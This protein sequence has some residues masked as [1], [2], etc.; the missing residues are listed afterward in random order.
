MNF[1]T[2]PF[3]QLTPKAQESS[4]LASPTSVFVQVNQSED[5]NSKQYELPVDTQQFDRATQLKLSSFFGWYAIPPLMPII[6]TQLDLSDTD[7]LNSDIA[8]TASTI[9]SRLAA[10]PLLDRY[11]PQVVQKTVLWLGALP[12]FCAAFV[13]S[14]T[15]LLALRFLIGIVGCVFVT[16]QYWT[17]ITF[18]RNV[19]G[20]AN[21]ITGGFGLSGIG[22]AFLLLPFIYQGIIATG[23]VSEDIGWR[24]TIAFPAFLMLIMSGVIH[25][26]VDSCPSGKFQ[27]FLR[28]QR[29]SE[30][31]VSV[32]RTHLCEAFRRVLSD[33]NV[34]IM[35]AHYAACFGTELQLN[36]MGA[37]YF[38]NE[39]KQTDCT[40]TSDCSVLT[41]TS[42]ATVASS[43]GLM[44]LFA[45]AVGGIVSDAM[46]CRLE[47]RGRQYT[48]LILLCILG[49]LVMALS[50]SYN[51]ALCVTL[52]VLVAIA[53]QATGGS[54]YSIV[55]YLNEEY[56]GTVNGLV[57]AGGN[58]GGAFFGVLFR[59]TGSYNTGLFYMSVFI[60]FC[61]LLT[62]FCQLSHV[63]N[64]SDVVE[65][66]SNMS[67]HE[68]NEVY[69]Q[70]ANPHDLTVTNM[71]SGRR[72]L[73]ASSPEEMIGNT[74]FHT[75]NRVQVAPLP[76]TSDCHVG[77]V[78]DPN[79][80]C[81]APRNEHEEAYIP[82]ALA[83][84]QL[85]KVVADMHTMKAEQ[86]ENVTAIVNHYRQ[87]EKETQERHETRVRTLKTRAEEKVNETRKLYDELTKTG[88]ER[89][90]MYAREKQELLDE[91]SKERWQFVQDREEW[92]RSLELA[93]QAQED[94]FTREQ[95]VACQEIAHI[96]RTALKTLLEYKSLKNF[97]N[98]LE[99]YVEDAFGQTV[100]M[101]ELCQNLRSNLKTQQKAWIHYKVE[102]QRHYEVYTDIN[103]LVLILIDEAMER[104]E[105][106][107]QA[108]QW[109]KFQLKLQDLQTKAQ[110]AESQILLLKR[111]LRIAL[112]QYDKIEAHAVQ[113]TLQLLVHAVVCMTN[114]S[115]GVMTVNV[116]TQTQE[117]NDA[118]EIADEVSSSS[119]EYKKNVDKDDQKLALISSKQALHDAIEKLEAATDAKKT[120]K[121]SVKTW[122][123]AFQHQFG[124]EPSHEEKAQVKDKYR[125]FKH[126]EQAVI[127]QK[128]VVQTLKQ[129]HQELISKYDDLNPLDIQEK[130]ET[131][132]VLI[133]VAKSIQEGPS[134]LDSSPLLRP[135]IETFDVGV[136]A[137]VKRRD[138]STDADLN[139]CQDEAIDILKKELEEARSHLNVCN[140]ESKMT[141]NRNV[142]IKSHC[143]I[144]ESSHDESTHSKVEE[145]NS[146][147]MRVTKREEMD[148]DAYLAQKAEITRLS[149]EILQ[150]KAEKKRLDIEIEQLRCKVS[151][152]R[153]RG[154]SLL[155]EAKVSLDVDI[156]GLDDQ[157]TVAN[158]CEEWKDVKEVLTKEEE[159]L[160]VEPNL[161]E[162]KEFQ[163]KE[164]QEIKED[165][166]RSI[167]IIQLITDAV[168]RGKSHFNRGEKAKCYQLY[169]KCA[170]SCI[171][172]LQGLNDKQR[173]AVA[174]VLK[175][176]VVESVRL[177]PARG[178]PALRRQL[179]IVRESCEEWL[180]TREQ[181]ARG[182]LT[183]RSNRKD[184]VYNSMQEKS[185]EKKTPKKPNIQNSSTVTQFSPVEA[186][187]IEETRQKLRS[188]EASSKADQ[189]KI[190][191]LEAALAKNSINKV[192]ET[193]AVVND[194]RI[195]ELEKKHQKVLEENEV[196]A[197]KEIKAL[198]QKIQSTNET[199]QLLR[200]EIDRLQKEVT[201]T[202][203]QV[204]FIGE[205]ENEVNRLRN[206]TALILP[207]R[208]EVQDVKAQHIIL[209][210]RYREE[211]ALR[212]KYYNQ[213]EDMKG[214]IRVYARCRPMSEAERIRQCTNCVKVLD[215][216]SLEITGGMRGLKTFVYD[217]VFPPGSTQNQVFEDTKNL[218]QSA[219]DGYN[220]CIF[221]YGQTGSGKTFT[222]TGTETD[223]G[224]SPRAIY[225]LF[226]LAEENQVNW[227]I[228]FQATML[229]LYNDTLVDLFQLLDG[230]TQDVKLE[231]KKNEKGMVIV[232]NAL[233]KKCVSPDQTLRLFDGANK[234]R[235]VGATKM[236][237]E[238][239]RSH[240]IFS[241][242]IESYNKTTKVTTIGK[243][244]LVDLAGSERAGK[245]GATAERLKE[246]QAINKSLS[247]L[248]DVISALSTNEKFIPYRN[249]KLTQLMQDSLG[250]N[251]KTL[252]FVNISPADYNQE[253]TVT[254]LTYAS[255]VKLITNSAN[256]NSES[257]QVSRL[258][259]IIK[260]LRAGKSD[261]EFDG[262]LD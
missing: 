80:S 55:P 91:Q 104:V 49:T 9:F 208:N 188:L 138:S 107:I 137:V 246:A 174:S 173:R 116:R 193:N 85:K 228:T 204:K 130:N 15:S 71:E 82:V 244:S 151:E 125:A 122:L 57:G 144:L 179:D 142:M 32:Q 84:S 205:L 33:R 5:L 63:Q 47:M 60:F 148:Q 131:G 26:A 183:E 215:E 113:E 3:N 181:Q 50:Q 18:A 101:T 41:K 168:T 211:Q 178:I 161:F 239:S 16:S 166:A 42:A 44:N 51:L 2:S 164:S 23:I 67:Q 106:Q 165:A 262:V 191:Q 216:F 180:N 56:T 134:R 20:T 35:I 61:A 221:A 223:L 78:F 145:M 198:N 92:Q 245:T 43:F 28:T 169:T 194:R 76:L 66:V 81:P 117:L 72:N 86:V 22:F 77:Q 27:D 54:T 110:T 108:N 234:K 238:S 10:G 217:Q 241:L 31:E 124:R 36:N 21:A 105:H 209:E 256:K 29:R 147:Q 74:S 146:D 100:R 214:K 37:L 222:M 4:F 226:H 196:K 251:A 236:N 200:E 187:G 192:Q 96:S 242:L 53:A 19:A 83:R 68:P 140:Y 162:K 237:A 123:K 182:R 155:S 150:H 38:Y 212:K 17:T 102:V 99:M 210:T 132:K 219:V 64:H 126:A 128:R 254:S 48:Q 232:Q 158:E 90:K 176:I 39:F 261:I 159:D 195:L 197:K 6:K 136:E 14:A 172:E 114:E 233:M 157:L 97:S 213:I 152:S 13:Q 62:P 65:N 93:L 109:Q 227:N 111:Q 190:M 184:V 253:E 202:G 235:Q 170:E 258:K 189:K 163:E 240:S 69:D 248:G 229:E 243:L 252:M 185:E 127:L 141:E 70:L 259:A 95:N 115:S 118:I 206:E 177:P 220:V 112:N 249:N 89:D 225:H 24:I 119:S 25:F 133:E 121:S 129:Q 143:E 260:Q 207:L 201:Q 230:N 203:G 149:D 98:E 218:L 103:G 167:Q 257:E 199:C 154:L 59:V 73:R 255:R 175:R 30:Q 139:V 46:N 87:L 135:S 231:I 186:N 94:L 8:S 247:A 156:K 120:V 79:A 34:L 88:F 11:G 52:Y 1:S 45:R 12:I 40:N 160:P 58:M 75:S 224:L 250:G 153:D 171:T 7:V